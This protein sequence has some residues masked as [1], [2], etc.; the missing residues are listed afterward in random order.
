MSD[1]EHINALRNAYE[2]YMVASMA[3][4][5]DYFPFD[6]AHYQAMERFKDCSPVIITKLEELAQSFRDGTLYK[7]KKLLKYLRFKLLTAGVIEGHSTF[8][9]L[10]AKQLER[11][12]KNESI[13]LALT[14]HPHKDNVE[15]EHKTAAPH[16]GSAQQEALCTNT[17]GPN[18]ADAQDGGVALIPAHM[19]QPRKHNDAAQKEVLLTDTEDPNVV[20]AQ[21]GGV[22]YGPENETVVLALMAQPREHNMVTFHARQ[23]APNVVDAQGSGMA[24]KTEV[25]EMSAPGESGM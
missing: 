4:H 25:W 22:A 10:I 20:D 13:V 18:V 11:L 16:E 5:E 24:Q 8:A 7:V 6:L 15:V 17:A 23:E 2:R 12:K 3:L 9:E 19:A 1:L 21:D 14:A